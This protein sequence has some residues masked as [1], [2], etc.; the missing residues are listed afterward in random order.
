MVFYET[1]RTV[2]KNVFRPRIERLHPGSGC[3]FQIHVSNGTL[4]ELLG[5]QS[6]VLLPNI[7]PWTQ[8]VMAELLLPTELFQERLHCDPGIPQ[9]SNKNYGL[10]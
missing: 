9:T 2:F 1:D 8:V 5:H 6:E 3:G 10:E 7:G 4:G